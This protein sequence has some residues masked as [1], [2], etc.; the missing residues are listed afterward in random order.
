[1][2]PEPSPLPFLDPGL[3]SEPSTPNGTVCNCEACTERRYLFLVL[4]YNNSLLS[5]TPRFI[6]ENFAHT[7]MLLFSNLTVKILIFIYL[8][9]LRQN[10][11]EKLR[12][13]KTVGQSYG[14][15]CGCCMEGGKGI[16]MRKIPMYL[17]MS[18]PKTRFTGK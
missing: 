7:S 8:D 6:Y 13:F 2:Q 14:N 4:S 17:M 18:Q 15:L 16:C 12:N 10:M 3:D 1:M 11:T 5:L 9:K